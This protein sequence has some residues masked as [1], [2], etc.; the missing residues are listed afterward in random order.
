M[1]EGF[2][3]PRSVAVVG[4]ARE[5]GKVGHIVFDNLLAAGFAGPVYP[6]NPRA[7]EIH[8]HRTY[9]S[10]AELP[11]V[12]DLVIVVVPAQRVLDV[13]QDCARLRVGSAI[14]ISAGFKESGPEGGA[15][16]RE[17]VHAAS[18]GG[19]RLLGPNCLGLIST[20][21]ALNA[22]FARGM[23]PAGSISFMS[24]SGA[25]GTAIL[26]WAAGRGIG[27]AH[28]VSL[29]NKADVDETD[30]VRAWKDDANANV[31][32]A[33]LESVSDGSAFVGA[34]SDLT[35]TKP[36]L[37]L[38]SG[39]SDAGARAVSSHTG[40]LAGSSTA[41]EA[42]F[43]KAGIIQAEGVQELFDMALGFASQPLP[44]P[45]G[46][47]IL[48]N[49]GGPAVM[50]TDACDKYDVNVASLD[51]PT[52]DRLREVLPAAAALYN[53]VDVLGDADAER[54]AQAATALI[55]DD[56]VGALLVILTPQAMTDAAETARRIAEVTAGSGK[57]VL[58]CFMGEPSVEEAR[59]ILGRAGIPDYAFPERA[60]ATLASM[61]R[62]RDHL[63]R[64]R[65]EEPVLI[66]DREAVREVLSAVTPGQHTFVTE[67]AASR[68]VAAYGVPVPPGGIATEASEAKQIAAE[69]G[70]PVALKIASPDILHK[71]DI[72]GIRL[73]IA[74]EVELADAYEDIL[75]RTQRHMPDAIIR[76]VHVQ[77]MTPRGREV[78]VGV[79]RD[80][81][82][83][84]L[85][86]FGLGGVYVEV[87]RDVTFRLCPVSLEE[88]RRMLTEI[89]GFGLLRG[90]RGEE[91]ADLEA[92][93]DVIVRISALVTETPEIVELDINPLMVLP[94]GQGA[95]AA[96][97]RIGVSTEEGA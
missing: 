82:F 9:A 49:A 14:V 47:A 81:Q 24:Q 23:P 7:G 11:Q 59:A 58:A 67:E 62:F 8:G 53:P 16:E 30:L 88:A 2:F 86:M 57:T 80:P 29:G 37:A 76:G 27:L 78:I 77:K 84:P 41:Y 51:K 66:G 75:A 5:E 91:P 15:L 74:D 12:P 40:S 85:L 90:A 19:V 45:G 92:I 89:R 93:A 55:A 17:I 33:Y 50:A 44:S 94:K 38:K 21:T 52:I 68:T 72:G 83:G 43:R 36:L 22:S 95:I 97:V 46:V 39:T 25:L 48:T 65:F 96:D 26:D 61:Q 3:S 31:V 32:V 56:D 63:A 35:A 34:A 28:F 1:L 87:L 79:N 18:E 10:L 69:I 42:A 71:S 4:A 60:V 64:P 70:Y 73:N 20:A 6:V 54:Y 13:I